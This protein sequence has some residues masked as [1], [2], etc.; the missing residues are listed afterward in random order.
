MTKH[1]IPTPKAPSVQFMEKHKDQDLHKVISRLCELNHYQDKSVEKMECYCCHSPAFGRQWIYREKGMTI[2]K[3]CLPA[4]KM[5]T[6][7]LELLAY[8]GIENVHFNIQKES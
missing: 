8:Y 7:P 5:F 2:C 4:M 6:F 3:N 1:I